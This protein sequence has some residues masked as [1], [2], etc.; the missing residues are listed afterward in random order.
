MASVVTA[1]WMNWTPFS[2]G[3]ACQIEG[4][5]VQLYAVYGYTVDS[6]MQRVIS[7]Q[8]IEKI[9]G[10]KTLSEL[11]DYNVKQEKLLKSEGLPH[12]SKFK[13]I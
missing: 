2:E 5:K 4:K 1:T 6:K 8:K 11:S 7:E 12:N 10:R 3:S 13:K 9:L